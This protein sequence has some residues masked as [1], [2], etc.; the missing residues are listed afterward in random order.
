M[1]N[2]QSSVSSD[3][4]ER[5][6]SKLSI[7]QTSSNQEK[8]SCE[9][10]IQIG[11]WA[12]FKNGKKKL[13]GQILSISYSNGKKFYEE[14]APIKKSLKVL[15]SWFELSKTGSITP[16]TTVSVVTYVNISNYLVSVPAP[17]LVLDQLAF[18][19]F[20]MKQ[21]NDNLY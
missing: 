20:T 11:N 8:V 6:K 10:D 18:N 21:I 19:A 9:T 7:V 4:L 17:S 16:T 5:F 15:C 1:A 12:I 3:R 13:L 2:V 14:T